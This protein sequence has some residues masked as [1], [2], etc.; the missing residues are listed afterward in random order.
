MGEFDQSNWT[1]RK[2]GNGALV[3]RLEVF[4]PAHRKCTYRAVQYTRATVKQTLAN[5]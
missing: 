3:A 1:L 5:S 2:L 4:A